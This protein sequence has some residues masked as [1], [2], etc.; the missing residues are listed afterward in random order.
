MKNVGLT[1]A[2]V[3]VRSSRALKSAVQW[4][5]RLE[6]DDEGHKNIWITLCK[7]GGAKD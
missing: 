6:L 1:L 5:F 4:I 3:E 7:A 2:N